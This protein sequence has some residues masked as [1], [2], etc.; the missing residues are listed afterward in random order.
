MVSG[1][2][3]VCFEKIVFYFFFLLCLFLSLQLPLVHKGHG[4]SSGSM[5]APWSHGSMRSCSKSLC[6]T[7]ACFQN[8]DRH[9]KLKF[10]DRKKEEFSY[11][12]GLAG[13]NELGSALDGVCAYFLYNVNKHYIT[14]RSKHQFFYHIFFSFGLF[15]FIHFKY[16]TNIFTACFHFCKLCFSSGFDKQTNLCVFLRT[17]AAE[18]RKQVSRDYGSPQLGKKRGG[19]HHPVSHPVFNLQQ[20]CNRRRAAL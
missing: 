14:V 3:A 7:A 1:G 4:K 18:V 19:A 20:L 10:A 17:V 12:M 13:A 16:L 8:P 15:V 5:P 11:Y 6:G 9:Q 2:A